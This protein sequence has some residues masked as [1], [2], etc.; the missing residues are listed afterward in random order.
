MYVVE[1]ACDVQKNCRKYFLFFSG[2]MNSFREH[3]H[4]V[5]SVSSRSFAVMMRRKQLM[6]FREI[7]YNVRHD[8]FHDFSQSVLQSY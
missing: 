4:C 6:F 5:F 2:L 7:T 8:T 3:H 1:C